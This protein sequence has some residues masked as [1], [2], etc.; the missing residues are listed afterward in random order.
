MCLQRLQIAGTAF[1][2]GGGNGDPHHGA[3]PPVT[4]G[5]QVANQ[6]ISGLNIVHHD[7]VDLGIICAA[8]NRHHRNAH[9]G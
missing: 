3:D 6:G 1:V 9:I 7:R 5:D 2:P 8:V 4:I